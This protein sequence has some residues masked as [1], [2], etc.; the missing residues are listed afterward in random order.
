MGFFVM[1]YPKNW[2]YS[3]PAALL[4]MAP[5]DLLASLGMDIY[6]PVVVRMPSVL[7]TT[8]ATIQLTL[9]LYMI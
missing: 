4:L 5:F 7:Q 6:L 2:T 1:L 9:S 3:L 8:P